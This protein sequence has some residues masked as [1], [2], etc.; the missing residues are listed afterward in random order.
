[1]EYKTAFMDYIKRGSD[2]NLANYEKK[3]L[4]SMST[5]GTNGGY[6][7]LP[8]IQKIISD[9]LLDSCVM[10]KI[11]SI[12]EIST[13]SLDVIDNTKFSTSWIS[14]TGSVEDSDAGTCR[15]IWL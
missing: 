9:R 8:N 11:C 10:R 14:E 6:L 1:M 13:S 7:V 5:E 3:N 2:T 4:V 12:Q 15:K